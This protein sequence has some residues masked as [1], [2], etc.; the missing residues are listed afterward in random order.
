MYVVFGAIIALVAA[1]A[2]SF[3]QMSQLRTELVDTREMLAAEIAKV[4]ETSS[5]STRTGRADLDALKAELA[6]AR[7]QASQ[8]AGQA[9]VE[10]TRHADEVAAQLRRA[11]EE[12]AARTARETAKVA[13]SLT[14][15]STEVSQV[16]EDASSTATKVSEVSTN[17]AAVK[18][19]ADA[20]RTEL[21]RTI[22]ELASTKGDLG[23]QSGLIATNARQL[24]ALKA[25]GERNYT[26]FTLKK[27]KTTQRIGD[28]QIRLT[29]ADVKRN[30]YSIEVIV[31]DKKVE[32]KDRTVNEPVQFMLSRSVTPYEL[33]VNEVKKDMIAGYL[34]APKVQQARNAA[35]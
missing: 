20:T 5:V 30:R 21:E 1:T 31:D 26:E 24:A 19:Q 11:Q 18:S 14:A 12:V 32:K 4:A 27:A 6:A 33:V 15:V 9:R 17:L 29:N 3:Y 10:A 25:L 8:L 28:L 16:R 13:E 22:A 35:N 34:S 7:A 23:V 2:Y